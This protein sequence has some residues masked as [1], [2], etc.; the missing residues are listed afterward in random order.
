MTWTLRILLVITASPLGA[1][2]WDRD[3]ADLEP[4]GISLVE[5]VIAGRIPRYPAEYYEA[6]LRRL[7][8]VLQTR[9][10]DWGAF[11]DAAVACDRLGRL[12]E[13]IAWMER[14]RAALDYAKGTA[15][16]HWYR[17]RANLGTFHL[18]RWLSKGANRSQMDDLQLAR[19]L[20]S[21][22]IASNPWVASRQERA[23]L[24]FVEWLFNLTPLDP[25]K[26]LP[27]F[28]DAE[29]NP[30]GVSSDWRSK[31][32]DVSESLCA[33]IIHDGEPLRLDLLYALGRSISSSGNQSQAALA[34]LRVDDLVA[35][36]G[37][38][39]VPGA[40]NGKGL[41][42]LLQRPNG[43]LDEGKTQARVA[44]LADF[45][46]IRRQ[47]NE[48]AKARNDYIL[49]RL[50]LG[51]HPDTDQQFWSQYTESPFEPAGDEE[52][53]EQQTSLLFILTTMGA[54]LVIL[55]ALGG[56][57]LYVTRRHV[58]VPTVKDV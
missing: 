24:A 43:M 16:E 17:Y 45:K 42:E 38:S 34:M 22:C 14:K 35:A 7:T 44:V 28:A 30:L 12:D 6:R 8:E 4:R 2:L 11:D 41:Q 1:C 48:W 46:R 5:A 57:A 49:A 29:P 58:S 27:C 50:P 23:Q 54:A 40:P 10:D 55:A 21:A 20:L 19:D 52:R 31:V 37:L 33:L 36:G 39:L 32:G 13:A 3:M 51:R 53:L 47:A 18:H 25:G 56:F 15:P 26:P 9:S